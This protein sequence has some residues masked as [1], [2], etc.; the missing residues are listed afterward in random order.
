MAKS[1][2]AILEADVE[3]QQIEA[4]FEELEEYFGDMGLDES[5][6]SDES[7]A[8]SELDDAL[9]GT[10]FA[11][12]TTEAGS[13]MSFIEFA[14]GGE[15]EMQEF[16]KLKLPKLPIP[17]PVDI[18]KRLLRN[19]VKKIIKKLKNLVKR[20]KKYASCIPLVTKTVIAFKAGKYGTA[21][22]S[23]YRALKCIHSK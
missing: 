2:A 14:D 9:Q 12:A 19:K 5:P 6:E 4:E 15:E 3:I 13:S 8:M 7:D 16:I 1:N 11:A 10:E 22:A 21:L 17:N 18:A 23:G 20:Y